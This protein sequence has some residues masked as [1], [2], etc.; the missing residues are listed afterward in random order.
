MRTYTKSLQD[1]YSYLRELQIL[2]LL[3]QRNAPVPMIISSNS[4]AL[5]IEMYDA[6]VSLNHLLLQRHDPK[7]ADGLI[8]DICSKA[9]RHRLAR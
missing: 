8:L 3:G 5:T 7:H 6:G 1:R 4:K 9:I 2:E